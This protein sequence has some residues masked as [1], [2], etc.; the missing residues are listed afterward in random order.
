MTMNTFKNMTADVITM[1]PS[2]KIMIESAKNI[3]K[4]INKV[5]C[6]GD[7]DQQR[8]TENHENHYNVQKFKNIVYISRFFICSFFCKLILHFFAHTQVDHSGRR[9]GAVYGLKRR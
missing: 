9:N 5:N 7:A 2:R 1:K 8:P 6:R 3:D 4:H